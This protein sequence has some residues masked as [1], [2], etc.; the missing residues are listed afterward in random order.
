LADAE[1]RGDADRFH[2][3]RKRVKTLWYHARLLA[4][5][6]HTQQ[7]VGA[8]AQL[9]DWLGEDHNVAV[10][11]ERLADMPDLRDSTLWDAIDAICRDYQTEL[12]DQ[13]LAAGR[14]F[15]AERPKAFVRRWRARDRRE[16]RRRA[17]A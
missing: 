14:R 9:E 3:W 1:A 17:A 5:R 6:W 11:R 12:R 15:Y 16:P 8:L 2:R 7:A 13:A 10:L 4:S